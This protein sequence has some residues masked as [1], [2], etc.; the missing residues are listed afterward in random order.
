MVSSRI[1]PNIGIPGKMNIF[2]PKQGSV[3]SSSFT[4][5]QS[6]ATILNMI[7]IISQWIIIT[8]KVLYYFGMIFHYLIHIFTI[9]WHS[10][11]YWGCCVFPFKY[12][13]ITYNECTYADHDQA[14]CATSVDDY[15][16]YVSWNNCDAGEI[17]IFGLKQNKI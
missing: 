16:N 11:H 1:S 4:K 7:S 3:T 8:K 17:V 5:N 15:G 12:Y 2:Q 9:D 6:F 13:G 14:W 10:V